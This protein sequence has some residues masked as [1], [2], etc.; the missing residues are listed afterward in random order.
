[1]DAGGR[2]E[3]L[4]ARHQEVHIRHMLRT[5]VGQLLI[6][7]TLPEDLRDHGRVLD[8]KGIS[9]LLGELAEKHPQAYREVVKRLSDVGRDAAYSTGGFSFGLKHLRKSQAVKHEQA[10]LV[11]KLQQIMANPTLG[12]KA[13]EDALVQATSTASARLPDMIYDESRKTGN[14]LADQV[15]SGSRG[16]KIQLRGLLGSDGLYVDNEDNVIPV[17]ILK[18]YSEGL[19]P[20][21]FWA[22]TFGARKGV[23]DVKTATGDAGY[24]AKQLNQMTHRLVVTGL[25]G[26]GHPGVG[27]PTDTDDPDNEGALLA[28]DLAGYKRN[29]LLTPKVL[30][31]IKNKG[32]ERILVRSP[33]VG[34]PAD[35]GVYAR[36]V[37]VRERGSMAP[38]GDFVGM[39]A[40]QALSE[41]LTQGQLASK[42]TGGVAGADQAVTGFKYINQLVQVPKR[43][44]AGATHSQEDGK[45]RK[46]E[47]APQGGHYVYINGKQHYV[48]VGFK[49]TVKPGDTV[50]AGDVL[51]EGIPNPSEIVKHKGIGEGRRYFAD[52][53]RKAYANSG[54]GAHRRNVEL[55]TRGLINHVRLSDEVGDH[56][57]DDVVPYSS[58]EHIYKPRTG[59]MISDPRSAKNRYLERPILHYS[60]GT[61]LRP[62]VLK[63]LKHFDINQVETHH[64]PPPFQAEMIRAASSISYDPDWF[65]RMLGSGQKKSLLGAVHRGGVSSTEGTSFVPSLAAGATFGRSGLSRGRK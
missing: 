28:G 63:E 5:T 53:F 42:H 47:K 15:L 3:R 45:I 46:V 54:L 11:L 19:S 35:G 9:K 52:A 6:N 16:N 24:L 50:E 20:V 25:D 55:L 21:E 62:S 40:A 43:F 10:K 8:K 26:K 22:G 13:K 12:D 58:L 31:D 39:A 32:H 38:V 7:D 1:M 64:E 27:F 29:T 60:I 44:R 18:S 65:T 17:P 30:K 56:V 23:V 14:P 34:G 57:P 49:V 61:K 4:A 37:G 51:S 48:D 36:D 41:N 59:S 33:L 2:W